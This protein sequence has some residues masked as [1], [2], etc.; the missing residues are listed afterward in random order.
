ML[1]AKTAGYLVF[2]FSPYRL[3]EKCSHLFQDLCLYCEVCEVLAL[4]KFK[5][6]IRRFIQGLFA[7]VNFDPVSQLFSPLIIKMIFRASHKMGLTFW[8]KPANETLTSDHKRKNLWALLSC[9]ALYGTS[10]VT[11]KGVANAP[12]SFLNGYPNHTFYSWPVVTKLHHTKS[13]YPQ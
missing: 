4:Y 11:I 2:F 9:D 10:L 7:N 5:L 12:V 13:N 6:H 8:F 3:R 1:V